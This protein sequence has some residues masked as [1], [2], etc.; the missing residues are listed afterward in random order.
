MGTDAK[1]KSLVRACED[2]TLPKSW[3]AHAAGYG[4]EDGYKE[5]RAWHATEE[6]SG[7]PP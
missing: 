2:G 7:P 3:W 1:I 4:Y 5:S 6:G